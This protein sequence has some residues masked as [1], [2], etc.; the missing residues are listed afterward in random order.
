M[1]NKIA[2]VKELHLTNK[3]EWVVMYTDFC[4]SNA[5]FYEENEVSNLPKAVQ[6]FIS[7]HTR[8]EFDDNRYTKSF[9]YK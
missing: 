7:K 3:I 1:K 5:R 9:I 4:I 8:K 6:N 2:W